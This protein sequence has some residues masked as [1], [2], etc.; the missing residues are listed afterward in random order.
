M[1][2]VGKCTEVYFSFFHLLRH[3]SIKL[4]EVTAY[5]PFCYQF[6]CYFVLFTNTIQNESLLFHFHSK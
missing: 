4:F 1:I 6:Q 2:T 5:S 3:Q